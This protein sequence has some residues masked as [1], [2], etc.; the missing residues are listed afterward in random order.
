MTE[1]D[2]IAIVGRVEVERLRVWVREGWIRPARREGGVSYSEIDVAR[3]QL[4]C[5]LERDLAIDSEGMP[6]V[7]ALLDQVYGLRSRLRELAAA[8]DAQPDEVR[9]AI[10]ATLTE[11]TGRDEVYGRR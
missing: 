9:Q 8:I 6:L 4:I 1:E 11:H 2:V 10:R 3:A 7:L 5:H